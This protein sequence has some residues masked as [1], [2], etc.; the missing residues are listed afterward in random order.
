MTVLHQPGI[1]YSNADGMSHKPDEYN[2]CDCYRAVSDPFTFPCGGSKYCSRTQQQWSCFDEDVDY[3]VPLTMKS[4]MVKSAVGRSS[5]WLTGYSHDQLVEALTF[6]PCLGKLIIWI[7]TI[8][9]PMQKNLFP[10]SPV[11]KYFFN[12][13]QL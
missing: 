4:V 8:E 6:D 1:K 3:I 13:R 12:C 9:E 11:V 10:C 7:S 2:F 5:P